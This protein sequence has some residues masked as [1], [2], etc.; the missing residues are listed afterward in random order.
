MMA[1]K[2]AQLAWWAAHVKEQAD[3][4]KGIALNDCGQTKD[5][6]ILDTI[7]GVKRAVEKLEQALREAR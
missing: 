4:Y 7:Q 5:L 3:L 6:M 1:S 2:K